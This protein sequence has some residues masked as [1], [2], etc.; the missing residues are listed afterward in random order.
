MQSI[1]DHLKT[2]NFRRVRIGIKNSKPEQMPVEKYVLQKF[3]EEEM[4]V[5]DCLIG[6]IV[7]AY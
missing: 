5:V 7:N 6:E 1:I 2:K 4:G 3:S